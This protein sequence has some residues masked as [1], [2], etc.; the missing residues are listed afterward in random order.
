MNRSVVTWSGH[1]PSDRVTQS[2]QRTTGASGRPE[3]AGG[4]RGLHDVGKRCPPAAAGLPKAPVVRCVD[5]VTRSDGRWPDHVMTLRFT[6][7]DVPGQLHVD[8]LAHSLEPGADAATP[9][10]MATAVVLRRHGDGTTVAT[11]SAGAAADT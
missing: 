1:R 4:K 8:V 6:R 10:L 3:A 5:W 9:P 2:T 11:R 7:G